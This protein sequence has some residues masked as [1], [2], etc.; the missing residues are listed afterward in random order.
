MIKVK[1][2]NLPLWIGGVLTSIF[3]VLAIIG[4]WI[5]PYT[6]TDAK[7]LELSPTGELKLT[8]APPS[9]EHWLGRDRL[10]RDIFS[11]LLHGL[12]YTI[13]ITLL[14]ALI[15]LLFGFFIGLYQGMN[16]KE[17]S[18]G[19]S[20]GYLGA[21]PQ[22]LLLYIILLPFMEPEQPIWIAVLIQCIVM[23]LFGIPAISASVQE[24]TLLLKER[25]SVLVSQTM[26]ASR[27]WIIRKHI[28]PALKEDLI[29]MF[30]FEMILVLNLIGQLSVLHI[31]LGGTN[32]REDQFGI[33]YLSKTFEWLG[34][35]GQDQ[36]YIV[37]YP[38]LMGILV[39]SYLLLLLSFYL[40]SKGLERKYRQQYSKYPYM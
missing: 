15:R 9:E 4:P 22:I 21:I 36:N 20:I 35:I 10:G 33:E 11:L 39:G 13:F 24:K 37:V 7:I 12:K 27:G 28:L 6:I 5:A 1:S 23:A 14:V 8:P 34:L 38:W 29:M 16:G 32:V 17:V 26:G 30:V 25:L 40:L 3:I 18:R 19:L 2:F 31:F